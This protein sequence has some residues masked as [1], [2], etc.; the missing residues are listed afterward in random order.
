MPTKGTPLKGTSSRRY[1]FD[2]KFFNECVREAVRD[3]LFSPVSLGEHHDVKLKPKF[4]TACWA[5][6]P[7]HRIYI[8]TDLFEK[9]MVKPGLSTKQQ[10]KYIANHYHHELGHALYT[11]RDM[12]KIQK[13]LASISAPFGLY[14][15]FEDAY[16]EDR[17]RRNA[18]YRF[19]WLT[20]E[21]LDFNPRPESL[22]FALI[23]AEGDEA[24]VTSALAAWKPEAPKVEP[25]NP[26]AALAM[27][28][29]PEPDETR[30]ALEA[31]LPRVVSYYRRM[32]AVK[33]S[34][35][36]MP[37]LNAWLDEFGRPPQMPSAGAG[38]G[39]AD[40]EQSAKMMTD[41]KEAED[42]DSDCKVVSGSEGARPDD[43]LKDG[44]SGKATGDDSY[45]A[46][47]K[48]GTVLH[49]S[50][51]K[52]DMARAQKLADKFKKFFAEKSRVVSTRTPQ[53][54]MSAR[55]FALN[56]SPYRRTELEGRGCKNVF[57]E[58]DCSGSMGGFHIMEGKVLLT[59]LSIL[60]RA[61]HVTGHVALSAV[62]DGPSWEVF[63]LPVAQEVIDRIQGYAGAEGLEFTLRDNIALAQKADYV[64]V[65]TDAQICD[66]PIDKS[67]FHRHGVYTWGLYAGN[68]GS[69]FEE[70]IK[71]FD[72]ALMRD[73]AEELV[74][75]MLAQNK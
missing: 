53:T 74:D 48:K 60:A 20:L 18:E 33:D 44:K 40:L 27:L 11:E 35:S 24:V 15:L 56:R 3:S 66:K 59:A 52:V 72:K 17:Y 30:E 68:H 45:K 70:L 65:Y 19:E 36:L 31:K 25:G 7:P 13:A 58:I 1:P 16:M 22:L 57:L 47:S 55:H 63:K 12:A 37:L 75:A 43:E 67:Y 8:G 38:A 29:G 73:N 51:T 69:Y 61:G 62:L 64:F 4:E 28:F 10:A 50:A 2:E 41:P 21:T 26:E 42:F 34:M 32:C 54:R 6:L 9:S 23:Q 39:L 5:Y 71:Y 14:N 46:V 49:R